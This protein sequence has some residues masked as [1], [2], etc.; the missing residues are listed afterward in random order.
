L[1]AY[2][3]MLI[4]RL[5]RLNQ[6]RI[7]RALTLM[8]LSSQRVFHLIPALFHFNYQSLPGFVDSATPQGVFDYCVNKIQA[9]YLSEFESVN[10]EDDNPHHP[11]EILGLYTMGSTASVGQ[12][13]SS[14][15]DIWVCISSHMDGQKK[16][17]V[18]EEVCGNNRLG[19]KARR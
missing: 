5:D 12:S 8:N 3:E 7:E 6:Q 14:D 4:T 2:T 13:S 1:Q 17:F 16:N 18:G 9:K 10:L 15:L 11:C 19:S